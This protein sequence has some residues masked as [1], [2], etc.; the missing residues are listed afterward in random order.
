MSTTTAPT[1]NGQH[2]PSRTTLTPP[3]GGAGGGFTDPRK[4]E[5]LH[6]YAQ[7]LLDRIRYLQEQQID[8][9]T[10]KLYR[11]KLGKLPSD[12][13]KEITELRDEL[14]LLLAEANRRHI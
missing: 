5:N 13:T 6:E 3:T 8:A 10:K 12:Y 14:D 1:S 9:Y 11:L 4:I 7:H 2:K